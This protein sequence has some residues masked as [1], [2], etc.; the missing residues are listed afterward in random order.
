MKI[1]KQTTQQLKIRDSIFSLL[2]DSLWGIT[3]SSLPLLMGWLVMNYSG[4][5]S[6]NCH[7][8]HAAKV[9]CHLTSSKLMGFAAVENRILSGVE[10]TV[11]EKE[12]GS[13]KEEEGKFFLVADQGKVPIKLEQI[14]A[15]KVNNL[16]ANPQEAFLRIK[17]DDRLFL[18]TFIPLAGIFVAIN[19]QHI[20]TLKIYSCDFDLELRQLIF[21]GRN[22]ISQ[23]C[24]EYALEEILDVKVETETDPHGDD[25]HQAKITLVKG[26]SLPLSSPSID[27]IDAE[28]IVSKVRSFLKL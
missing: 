23:D 2:F 11:F 15:R 7:R 12:R 10:G 3:F 4:V 5:T 16:V 8:V 19:L 18:I 20:L 28:E 1:V 27:P 22:L 21:K 25:W 9:N 24:Q 14:D 13:E 26:D 17:H 6:L